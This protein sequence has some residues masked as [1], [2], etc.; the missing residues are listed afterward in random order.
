[1]N[2]WARPVT[3]VDLVRARV[4]L[5]KPWQ[6][7]QPK[8]N[9]DGHMALG[10]EGAIAKDA[11]RGFA[12]VPEPVQPHQEFSA[13]A[14][15]SGVVGVLKAAE[16]PREVVAGT[17]QWLEH[18]TRKSESELA[19]IDAADVAQTRTE[20]DQLWGADRLDRNV[21][22]LGRYLD[23]LPEA[24]A[25]V[26][27]NARDPATGRAYL[28][29]PANVVRLA[30]LA[31]AP[32]P[33]GNGPLTIARIEAFMRTNRTAYNADSALQSRYREL[34]DERERSKGG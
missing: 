2:P 10:T 13:P 27:R 16:I 11:D 24:Q 20:L 30:G 8:V 9:A 14:A 33:A 1:M 26:I 19:T 32:Q 6:P 29:D 21:D 28:N 3:T 31:R 17:M 34:L 18:G 23:G 4:D 5:G 15:S 12:D 25:E 22:A 7:L